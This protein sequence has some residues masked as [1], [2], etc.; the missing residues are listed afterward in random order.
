MTDFLKQKLKEHA[1][2]DE[3]KTQVK[4]YA[5]T[6]GLE[7]WKPDDESALCCVRGGA[8]NDDAEDRVSM[9]PTLEYGFSESYGM[10]TVVPFVNLRRKGWRD[11]D[12]L[13]VRYAAM[14][15]T[16]DDF[17]EEW[18]QSVRTSNAETLND[19][20]ATAGELVDESR[21]CVRAVD[22]PGLKE[23][24]SELR[25]QLEAHARF[26]RDAGSG[27]VLTGWLWAVESMKN[28]EAD[29]S[30]A[31]IT[32]TT[33]IGMW[34]PGPYHVFT[35]LL[36]HALREGMPPAEGFIKAQGLLRIDDVTPDVI[37]KAQLGGL[38]A[39]IRFREPLLSKAATIRDKLEVTETVLACAVMGQ[40][41]LSDEAL[42]A[43]SAE[44]E[45]RN[46]FKPPRDAYKAFHKRCVEIQWGRGENAEW[47]PWK[48]VYQLAYEELG[49]PFKNHEAWF[50]SFKQA[51]WHEPPKSD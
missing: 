33:P 12:E 17:R 36:R 2:T 45:A 32:D 9:N 16:W 31:E 21:K 22:V 24:V 5:K 39:L 11:R 29:I 14:E 13:R 6:A 44:T 1:L 50:S 15:M 4:K 51:K 10:Q 46:K 41:P 23:T 27:Q 8:K 48:S 38:A 35:Q 43:V 25:S 7:T 3:E 20:E 49:S 18:N 19:F 28:R 40:P 37:V 26:L 34:D 42:K 47:L 30:F